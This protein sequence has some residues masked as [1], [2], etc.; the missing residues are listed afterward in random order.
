[1]L[2]GDDDDEYDGDDADDGNEDGWFLWLTLTLHPKRN[3]H[4]HRGDGEA[5]RLIRFGL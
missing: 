1:M 4:P 2:S 5:M 3:V